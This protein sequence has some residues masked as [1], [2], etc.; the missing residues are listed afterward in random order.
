MIT[1]EKYYTMPQPMVELA[2]QV[3][4]YILSDICR[5][6]KQDG[7][8]TATAEIQL[9]TLIS[10]G[11]SADELLYRVQQITDLSYDVLTDMYLDAAKESQRFENEVFDKLGE[12][13]PDISENEEIQSQI[14]AQAKQTQETF[15][16]L[17]GSMGF[18][19]NQ[20]G[21][22]KFLPLAKTYQY[23][24]DRAQTEILSGGV[25]GQQAIKRAIRDLAAS[26]IK[27]VSYDSGRVDQID[28]AVRR[29]T[30]T[31]MNQIAEAVN[32]E[33][34]DKFESPL[35]E[36]SAHGGARDTG[37]GYQN[38][39]QWQGKVYYWTQKDRWNRQDLKAKYPDFE[40][41]T[42]YGR[43][44]G[45]E[46]ANCRHS[47]RVYIDGVS[48]RLYTDEQLKNIDEP[49][50][51]YEGRKYNTYE[52]TQRQR[53]LERT[54]RK[55]KRIL[56][57]YDEAGIQS[58]DPDYQQAAL[59]LQLLKQEYKRFSDAA[60]LRE[61]TERAQVDGFTA[62]QS[63]RARAAAKRQEKINAE[64]Q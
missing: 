15:K 28:V 21:V 63:N 14:K 52:A 9:S 60:N 32:N 20:N 1:P 7:Y 64:K 16:N 43:V 11:W 27:T 37:S 13:P 54:Q 41:S 56:L 61:Q 42:G 44:D 55:Y 24:L 4:D 17:T 50:F 62:A 10:R 26:G 39:K 8:I 30:V 53:L 25:S 51:E 36:V 33:N 12:K 31:G 6:I 58:T 49:A 38:H 23:I 19:V 35:V 47:K 2:Q 29:A 34:I 5:R 22:Q 48:E 57:A 3:E 45:L 59:K 18:S 46:G 40:S